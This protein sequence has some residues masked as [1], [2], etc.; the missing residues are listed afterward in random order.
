MLLAKN[1]CEINTSPD[2]FQLRLNAALEDLSGL[3]TIANSIGLDKGE[4]LEKVTSDHHQLLGTL[5]CKYRKK[6]N[7]KCKEKE[8]VKLSNMD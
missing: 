8:W 5:M 2:Q 6:Q 4:L 3:K 1:P 7:L